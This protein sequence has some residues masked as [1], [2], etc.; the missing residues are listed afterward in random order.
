M[1]RI[2]FAL[3]INIDFSGEGEDNSNISNNVRI[4]SHVIRS[5]NVLNA[6]GIDAHVTYTIEA[7]TTLSQTMRYECPALKDHLADRLNLGDCLEFSSV[8]NTLL[9]MLDNAECELFTK[10]LIFQSDEEE[11]FSNY[12]PIY[13][14]YRDMVSPSQIMFL[15]NIGIN[16]ISLSYSSNPLTSFANYIEPLSSRDRYNPIWYKDPN[17]DEKIALIPSVK[18][19][20]IMDRGGVVK[21]VK[22]MRNYQNSLSNKDDLL[23][24]LEVD[25]DDEFLFGYHVNKYQNPASSHLS[26]KGIYNLFKKLSNLGYVTFT[27]PYKYLVKHSPQNEIELSMDLANGRFNGYNSW[28][29]RW[30]NTELFTKIGLSRYYS[31]IA[32]SIDINCNVEEIVKGRLEVLSANNFKALKTISNGT[33]EKGLIKINNIQTFAINTYKKATKNIEGLNVFLDNPCY[34]VNDVY[35]LVKINNSNK[36]VKYL[37]NGTILHSFKYP[38]TSFDGVIIKSQSD[39]IKLETAPTYEC[40]PISNDSTRIEN[41]EI[42]VNV[43]SSGGVNLFY[44]NEKFIKRAFIPMIKYNNKLLRGVMTSHKVYNYGDAQ[45]LK[46]KGE[47]S[48]DNNT[49]EYEIVFTLVNNLPCLYIDAEINY[50]ETHLLKSNAKTS[51]S[52]NNNCDNNWKE[53]M[54]FEILLN[55]V[56]TD[57]KPFSVIKSNFLGVQSRF[58]IDF[59][60]KTKNRKIDSINNA[61][62]DGYIAVTNGDKGMLIAESLEKDFNFAF[63][64][65]RVSYNFG[66]YSLKLNP[67]GTYDGSELKNVLGKTIFSKKKYN[68]Y[69]QECN[70]QAPSYNGKKTKVALMLAPFFGDNPSEEIL[71][72]SYI[73]SY[74]KIINNNQ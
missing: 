21:Y 19:F 44:K 69:N 67:F 73:H 57:E 30:E 51:K 22:K 11:A 68:N 59:G 24:M 56:A 6:R 74:H 39:L 8:N 31:Y 70:S 28:T 72:R 47:F 16:G 42:V 9:T 48:I 10:E 63:C 66:E 14:P 26:T 3:K 41:E 20:D 13:H 29:E 1:N 54:P 2:F 49:K 62:T 15:K 46:I 50:P 55:F 33:N 23:L 32:K 65:L 27:T 34:M 25:S 36:N 60:A 52:I 18:T 12:S 61:I 4:L 17:S 43:L 40:N 5:L 64:P 7:P 71:R 35:G 53:V 38:D 45:I 58:E 37:Q